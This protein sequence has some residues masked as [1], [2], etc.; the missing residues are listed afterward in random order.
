MNI[1]QQNINVVS[2]IYFCSYE[3]LITKFEPDN[4]YI[5]DKKVYELYFS[6]KVINNKIILES[7]EKIKTQDALFNL[8][9]DFTRF[10]VNKNTKIWCIGGGTLSDLVGFACSIYKRG[11]S[12]NL[13]PTTLLS[14]ADASIG[15]KNAINLTTLKNAIGTIYLPLN[16]Y[17]DLQFL[18]S[19]D[20]ENFL[21]GLI[22]IIKISLLFSPDLW[23]NIKEKKNEIKNRDYIT[24]QYIIDKS[25]NLKVDIVNNDLLDLNQRKFLNLGHTF[26]HSF[27]IVENIPHGIAVAKGLYFALKLSERFCNLNSDKTNDIISLLEFLGIDFSGLDPS[28]INFDNLRNDKKNLN[29]KIT[30]V[31][32]SDLFQPILLELTED[33]IRSALQNM[34]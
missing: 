12:F 34:S 27:E 5:I 17:I 21:S 32:L 31:L 13:V 29:E 33:E 10:K 7:S 15:G 4:L 19:L 22:E 28:K 30:T 11:I 1:I 26:G 3:E 24:L 14:M 20:Y 9:N 16:V 18:I 6:D 2:E 8:L 25:V 23:N